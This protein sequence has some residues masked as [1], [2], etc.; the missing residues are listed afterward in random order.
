MNNN[1]Y[2]RFLIL[3]FACN[4][5]SSVNISR[6]SSKKVFFSDFVNFERGERLVDIVAYALMPNHF[7]LVLIERVEGGIS[8]F[9]Q[10]LSTGYVNYFNTRYERTGGLFEGR[11]KAKHINNQAYFNYIFVYVN[12]NPLKLIDSDWKENGISDSKKAKK[13]LMNYKY[14]SYLDCLG[15][16]RLENI[17]LNREQLPEFLE[18]FDDFEEFVDS[19]AGLSKSSKSNFEGM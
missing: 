2:E 18:K 5:Q 19:W 17:I 16:S 12:L 13:F 14:S 10:K 6:D 9:M 3:L 4:G 15:K 7:H 8:K 11:F 1:D